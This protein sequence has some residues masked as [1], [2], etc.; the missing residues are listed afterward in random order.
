[1]L[2]SKDKKSWMIL[3]RDASATIK[4]LAGHI[5]LT[6]TPCRDRMMFLTKHQYMHGPVILLNRNKLN[7]NI[8]AFIM[9]KINLYTYSRTSATGPS[10]RHN[11]CENE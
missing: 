10:G 6:Q 7:L 3:Q 1:M 4:S 11:A 2:D 5:G 8:A 9:I